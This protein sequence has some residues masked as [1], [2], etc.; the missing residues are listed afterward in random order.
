ME[1]KRRDFAKDASQAARAAELAAYFTHC[2]LQP[3]HLM[4]TLNTAQT[5]FFK[6]KNYKTCSSFARR[7]LDLGPRPEMASKVRVSGNS[8]GGEK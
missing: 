5:A 3:V 4:L 7:L 6:L 2:D 1:M 8:A